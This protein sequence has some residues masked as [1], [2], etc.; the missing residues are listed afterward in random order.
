MSVTLQNRFPEIIAELR[1]RLDVAL[2]ETA[3]EIETKA[4]ARAP[5]RVPFGEGLVAAIHTDRTS[6]L[7]YRVVGGDDE[8][9][10][11][12]FLEF[13]TVKMSPRPF[14]VPAFE[15]SVEDALQRVTTVL[16]T[17]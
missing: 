9:W 11:G 5:D 12:H 7:H 3:A 6:Q 13:G 1:P 16:S 15:E 17:L 8:A 4:K 10:Y 2:R 14:L